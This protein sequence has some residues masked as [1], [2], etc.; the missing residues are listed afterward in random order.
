MKIKIIKKLEKY[1]QSKHFDKT[2]LNVAQDRIKK[3][4]QNAVLA[5]D[6][7]I[8]HMG[9][10]DVEI[11]FSSPSGAETTPLR[12]TYASTWILSNL[13]QQMADDN[14]FM[15][16][17]GLSISIATVSG[18]LNEILTG[19][20]DATLARATL[21]ANEIH[22]F[23]KE[24][25]IFICQETEQIVRAIFRCKKFKKI[26]S[27][28]IYELKSRY[29]APRHFEIR[30]KK[31]LSPLTGRDSEMSFLKSKWQEVKQ[32]ENYT[33]ALRA[34]L[35]YGKSRLVYELEHY[36]INNGGH[37]IHI[38][39]NYIF[40]S[41]A[42]YPIKI[43][44]EQLFDIEESWSVA[45]KQK[46]IRE[47]LIQ[48]EQDPENF[49]LVY[50]TVLELDTSTHIIP[51][52]ES[53]YETLLFSQLNRLL[54]FFCGEKPVLTVVEDVEWIDAT[55]AKFLSSGNNMASNGILVIYTI[56]SPNQWPEFIK[57]V[58]GTIE[59]GSLTRKQCDEIIAT[60]DAKNNLSPKDRLRIRNASDG[61]PLYIE[62]LV[63]GELTR[64]S[65]DDKTALFPIRIRSLLGTY[66]KPDDLTK[67]ILHCAAIIGAPFT[68]KL[69]QLIC[70]KTY[71][72]TLAV[73]NELVDVGILLQYNETRVPYYNFRHR[74]IKDAVIDTINDE[75][76]K[77]IAKI[78]A[79]FLS[80]VSRNEFNYPPEIIARFWC[81]SDSPE[82]S[83]Q[84]F[85]EAAQIANRR[86]AYENAI[87]F[88]SEALKALQ[89][90]KNHT[91]DEV[92]E[93][94]LLVEM[95]ST[96]TRHLGVGSKQAKQAWEHAYDFSIRCSDQKLKFKISW[97]RWSIA[98][99]HSDLSHA[100]TL[101]DH[102]LVE[103]QRLNHEDY[104]LEA[105]HCNW[106]TCHLTGKLHEAER[107]IEYGLKQYST[108]EHAKLADSFGGHDPGVCCCVIGAIVA[109]L[110]GNVNR[111]DKLLRQG[112][113]IAVKLSNK[114][115]ITHALLGGLDVALMRDD[116]KSI[117]THSNWLLG[118]SE[119]ERYFD[120]R[121]ISNIFLG[122]AHVRY[123]NDAMGISAIK[124][125]IDQRQESGRLGLPL[126]MWMLWDAEFRNGRYDEAATSLESA[127][128]LMKYSG[129]TWWHPA[130]IL[131]EI[132]MVKKTDPMNKSKFYD[133]MAAGQDIAQRQGAK[134]FLKKF[135]ALQ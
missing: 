41:T 96:L 133:L 82:K 88:L 58:N 71:Q 23:V 121:A 111:G 69:I 66:I 16:E 132:A 2:D 51:S 98:I 56:G 47:F 26:N 27:D 99:G 114:S 130:L 39:C 84:Y 123:D 49:E 119:N 28:V 81:D 134:Y 29:P 89:M 110:R 65:R 7:E 129:E 125:A 83:T 35:G 12:S 54:R 52:N 76:K 6:G 34:K 100:K 55:T 21:K 44:L 108:V 43:L 59:L 1:N 73:L 131:A 92:I 90:S 135:Y 105:S 4:I 40:R 24:N 93:L 118:L 70:S 13:H 22:N 11:A 126:H 53:I 102:M 103:A 46:H 17:F 33:I 117:K 42:W 15:N 101:S 112:M 107:H 127:C 78:I 30:V 36:V 94:E 31:G 3:L 14:L 79:V 18:D 72:E 120:F 104:R 91:V 38:D 68:A 8:I 113:D 25:E 64:K 86:A 97:G 10:R 19:A 116:F 106:T 109:N 87:G 45:K 50:S 77:K 57:E 5:L 128:R 67:S 122:W 124:Q 75:D 48:N 60:L 37:V 32:I 74:M 95:A 20:E 61:G 115:S 85:M 9:I 80:G 63:R 62:E